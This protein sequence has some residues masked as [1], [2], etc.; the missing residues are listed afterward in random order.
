MLSGRIALSRAA[1]ANNE[2]AAASMGVDLRTYNMLIDLQHRDI[3][4]DDYETLRR[5]DSQVKPK[6]LS[7]SMLEK[8]APCW[9]I[10]EKQSEAHTVSSPPSCSSPACVRL[11]KEDVCVIC[12]E[13]FDNGESV[14]RLPCKHVFH[15]RCIDEWLMHCSDICP[16]D[17]LPV[18]PNEAAAK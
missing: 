14:R 2:T 9:H 7:R 6:T 11:N 12:L 17:G 4:P 1:R 18:L 16:E 10:P 8:H 13:P 3:T 15:T 5:L